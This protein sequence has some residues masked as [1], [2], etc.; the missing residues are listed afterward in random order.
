MSTSAAST[1]PTRQIVLMHW[2]DALEE[3][4]VY[5]FTTAAARTSS[6][7]SVRGVEAA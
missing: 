4:T 6:F 5:V 7:G 3:S 1:M 2:S